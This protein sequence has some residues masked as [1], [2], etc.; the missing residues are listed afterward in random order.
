MVAK[1][2]VSPSLRFGVLLIASIS[3]AVSACGRSQPVAA[4]ETTTTATTQPATTAPTT[5]ATTAPE[6]PTPYVIQPGDSVGGIASAFGLTADELAN[7]NNLDD[8]NRIAAGQQ[9]LIPPGAT[10]TSTTPTTAAA[11]PPEDPQ[12]ETTVAATDG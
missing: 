1:L 9:L 5:V 3:L 7:Y 10:S 12:P 2:Q 6:Q 11:P 4:G 8:P